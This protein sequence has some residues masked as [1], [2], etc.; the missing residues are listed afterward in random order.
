MPRGSPELTK[1]RRDEIVDAC[2]ELYGTMDFRDVTIKVIAERTSFTRPSIYNYFE[3]REEIFL[4]LVQRE[5]DAWAEDL[6]GCAPTEGSEGRLGFAD[7]V[8]RTLSARGC[9]LRLLST[10]LLEMEDNCRMENLVEFKRSYFDAVAELKGCL[11]R[12]CPGIPDEEVEGFTA[13][14]LPLVYGI[15]PYAVVSDK[16]LEAMHRVGE[17]WKGTSV[18]ELAYDGARRLLG[19]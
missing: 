17:D 4:A 3:T 9:L 13:C 19:V 7:C 5:Y 1:S 15:H 2:A 12:F 10:N 18:Y 14:F 11:R 16:I 8:A 6:R